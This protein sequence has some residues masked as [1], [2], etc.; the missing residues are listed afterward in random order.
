MKKAAFIA[1]I[2][3]ALLLISCSGQ[4]S[5]ET[6]IT[7]ENTV[8]T[9]APD[10]GEKAEFDFS[11]AQ[12]SGYVFAEAGEVCRVYKDA[13]GAEEYVV[14]KPDIASVS[15]DGAVTVNT[16]GVSL[17]GYEK[18]GAACAFIICAFAEGEG[19]SRSADEGSPL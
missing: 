12:V 3:S 17:V 11:R 9:T 14:Q 16:A 6:Q 10:E 13:L 19:P 2:L 5:G 15:S 8:D 18:D 7:T 1:L 4:D